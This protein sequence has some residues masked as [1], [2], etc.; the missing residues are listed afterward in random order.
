MGQTGWQWQRQGVVS[1]DFSSNNSLLDY[2]II[3]W[4][5]YM[6]FHEYHIGNDTYLS[7]EKSNKILEDRDRRFSEIETMMEI[8]KNLFI[9]CP[10]PSEC[11]INLEG[12]YV[13]TTIYDFL[14]KSIRDAQPQKGTGERIEFKGDK[15]LVQFWN[16]IKEHVC[17]QTYFSEKVGNPFLFVEGT[18]KLVGTW[19]SKEKGN[20]FFLPPLKDYHPDRIQFLIDSI[21]QFVRDMDKNKN[22]YILPNWTEKYLLPNEESMKKGLFQEKRKL[23]RLLRTIKEKEK[24]INHLKKN[25]LLLCADGPSL[26]E[27]VIKILKKIGFEAEKGPAKRTDIYLKYNNKIAVAEVKGIGKKSAGERDATQLEKWSSIYF[28]EFK[29]FPKGFLIVNA[30]RNVPPMD[31]KKPAF[32]KQMLNYCKARKHCLL[33]TTQLLCIHLDIQENPDKRDEIILKLF[34]TVG[35]YEGHAKLEDYITI[36]EEKLDSKE[37]RS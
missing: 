26:E 12:Q 31:R 10:S 32:P 22:D 16:S 17:Y 29:L 6:I 36:I 18:K 7:K 30:F 23:K 35:I 28:D 37:K 9:L 2:D 34:D 19:F 24:K 8:G 15:S 25:K 3:I 1:F 33:T 14:P 27:Q 20:V 5:P 21:N 4:D 11:L 13:E